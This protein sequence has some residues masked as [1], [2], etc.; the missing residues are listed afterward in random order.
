MQWQLDEIGLVYEVLNSWDFH[1]LDL[2]PKQQEQIAAWLLMNNPGSCNYMENNVDMQ[3]L[4]AFIGLISGGYLDNHFHNFMHAVDVTHT[5]FRYLTLIQAERIFSMLDQFALLVAAVGHDLGHIGLTNGFLTE[6]QHEL[7]IRYNDRSPLENLHCSKLFE[8]LA[9]APVNIFS[10][11]TQEQFKDIRKN[12]IDVIL[13]TD[14][15]Q[16]PS[17]VKEL[18]LLYEMNSKVFE[19]STGVTLSEAEVEVLSTAEN[20]KLILEMV[21]HGA[22]I[23]NPTKPWNICYDWAY[24]VLDE[25]ANQGDQ[26]KKL[27]IPVQVLNDR[28]KV[29]RPNSQIGFIEFIIAPWVCAEVKVF[30]N[31]SAA[32]EHLETNLNSWERTWIEESNPAEAE[33]EKVKE[34]VI[35]IANALRNRPPRLGAQGSPAHQGK[36]RRSGTMN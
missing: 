28:E 6:V 33:K 22:D 15:T 9:Q 32:S 5:S 18:E 35:K 8:I 20:K 4:R 17:M 14:I 19:A 21:L 2:T 30:P 12:I 24:R 10:G 34:R 29:N 36:K 13:H 25:Y 16:H 3:K 31:L 11:V 23:S 26:E 7:A 1:V 27:G